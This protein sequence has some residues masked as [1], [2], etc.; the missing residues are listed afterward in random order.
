MGEYFNMKNVIRGARINNPRGK[1]LFKAI[2]QTE[3]EIYLNG[4]PTYCPVERNKMADIIDFFCITRKVS[5]SLI[6]IENSF[7]LISDHSPILMTICEKPL[8]K[9]VFAYST[10]KHND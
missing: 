4:A 7:D 9:E 10:S 3:C 2:D 1:E 8:T 5:K 6:K